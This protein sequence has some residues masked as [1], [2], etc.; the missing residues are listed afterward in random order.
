M[1]ALPLPPMLKLFSAGVA[2]GGFWSPPEDYVAP[3]IGPAF[4]FGLVVPDSPLEIDFTVLASSGELR[5]IPYPEQTSYTHVTLWTDLVDA[6]RTDIAVGGGLGWRHLLIAPVTLGGKLP[7]QSLQFDSNPAMDVLISADAQWRY[8]LVGPLHLRADLNA[9]VSVGG[10]PLTQGTHVYPVLSGAVGVDV[11]WEPPSDRD[12]DGVAD[13]EDRCPESLEDHDFFDDADGCLDPDD[14]KDGILDVTDQCK[15]SAEDPDGH[16]DTDGCPEA[17]NDKDAYPDVFDQCPNEAES[18]NSWQDGDGCPDV[19]P[20]ELQASL[21]V[22]RDIVFAGEV[23]DPTSDVAL[24]QLQ[25]LLTTYPAVVLGFRVYTDGEKGAT[26]ASLLT[27]AQSKVLY[28]WFIAH[29]VDRHRLDFHWGGDNLPLNADKTDAEHLENRRVE[30][31][32][33]DTVGAD[34]KTIEFNP[35]PL[36][37]W[38]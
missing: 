7:S 36:E 32:L 10:E 29:G 30:V 14:D 21:G 38:R 31:L 25:G 35:Q 6:Y 8:R 33:V 37:Q 20:A 16:Q 12:Q 19:L 18:E 23:L 1:L 3:D 27:L 17:N 34:G 28:A 26:A 2:F 5:E 4:R 22:R 9:M 24:T 13:T 15:G 11:R